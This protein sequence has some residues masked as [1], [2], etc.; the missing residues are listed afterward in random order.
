MQPATHP[1]DVIPACGDCLLVIDIQNDFLPGGSLA[2][3]A[4]DEVIRPLDN[5]VAEFVAAGL[6]VIF[7]R[8][9]HPPNHC[10]FR[11]FGGPWPVHCVAGTWGAEFAAA[12]TPPS[13]AVIVSKATAPGR[14]S[15]S[16]FEGTGLSTQLRE[17]GVKRVFVGG[18]ATEYC[19]L[20]T[21]EDAI[22]EGFA[23]VLL[24]DAIRPINVTPTDGAR[25]VEQM[26]RTGAIPVAWRTKPD[27]TRRIA[28]V[29]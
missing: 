3:A 21:V 27:G 13:H 26:I 6:P 19:V 10:S 16:D 18:L 5:Y 24:T 8:D 15:Y 7:S 29:N 20:A 4:G 17:L 14:E 23:V 9:W 1:L 28:I 2:V 22:R 25:A 11:E 12:L